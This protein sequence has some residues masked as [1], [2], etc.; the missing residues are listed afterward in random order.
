VQSR[1]EIKN[2]FN[3]QS[4]SILLYSTEQIACPFLTLDQFTI[5]LQRVP[6]GSSIPVSTGLV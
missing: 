3:F 4:T 6:A 2:D 5:L 1:K